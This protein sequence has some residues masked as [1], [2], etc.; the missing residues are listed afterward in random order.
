MD[1]PDPSVA[2]A[3]RELLCVGRSSDPN[4]GIRTL[5][6][7]LATLPSD[8]RLTLVDDDSPDNRVRK[9][10][11]EVGVLDRITLTGRVAS[12]ELVRR[13]TRATIVVV[14]SRY[15][16]FGL[17]ADEAMACGTP[18]VASRA[19]ALAEVMDA[20]GGGLTAP[21]DDPQALAAAIGRLFDDVEARTLMAKRGR[22]RVLELYAWPRIAASTAGIY[23]EVV[24]EVLRGRPT[25]TITSASVG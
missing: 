7:A 10:A 19:G 21:R 1:T 3:E 11:R 24:D 6:R 23:R 18:V 25:S 16:G 20:T 14:P 17:P 12:A 15:E 13:Y 4:K 9:W 22:E 8:V 5:I 2:K